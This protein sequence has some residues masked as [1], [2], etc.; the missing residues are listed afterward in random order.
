MGFLTAAWAIAQRIPWWVWA[1]IAAGAAFGAWLHVHDSNLREEVTA[2]RNAHWQE[3][4]TQIL[5][6]ASDALDAAIA[7]SR[8]RE[9][10]LEAQMQTLRAGFLKEL[11]D[12]KAQRERDVAAARAGTLRLRVPDSVCADRAPAGAPGGPAAG[13]DGAAAGQLPGEAGGRFL[14]PNITADLYALADDA[15]QVARQLAA[16]QKIILTDRKEAP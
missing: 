4:E 8:A 7:K 2:E 3:R 16:C 14:P 9:A 6:K 15:D 11:A 10:E 13:G 5:K 12:A 1:S